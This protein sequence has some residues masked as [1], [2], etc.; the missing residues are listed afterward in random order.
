MSRSL[1]MAEIRAISDKSAQAGTPDSIG[2][3]RVPLGALKAQ[4]A[5]RHPPTIA[6][7]KH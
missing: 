7:P 2:A 1:E 3:S 5:R 6:K 4:C